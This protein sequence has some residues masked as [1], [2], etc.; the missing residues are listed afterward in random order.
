ML[1]N[2]CINIYCVW[3][4]KNIK[5]REDLYSHVYKRRITSDKLEELLFKIYDFRGLMPYI[6]G[7]HKHQRREVSTW[8]LNNS[9]RSLLLAIGELWASSGQESQNEAKIFSRW[10]LDYLVHCLNSGLCS[11][12]LSHMN[13][14][15]TLEECVCYYKKSVFIYR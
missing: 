11:Q 14:E 4:H 15:D 5:A 3:V 12:N 8:R 2:D 13:Y 6:V 7:V 9:I 1:L 10:G